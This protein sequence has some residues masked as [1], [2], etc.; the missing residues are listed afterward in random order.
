MDFLSEQSVWLYILI[1]FGRIMETLLGIIWLILISRGER[2]ASSVIML[3][4]TGLWILVAGT[5]LVG[6]Q[7]DI[8]KSVIYVLASAV[9]VPTSIMV[10]KIAST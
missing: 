5:V 6:F 9:G 10:K 8:L 4:A 2:L 1:F 7:T 3:M